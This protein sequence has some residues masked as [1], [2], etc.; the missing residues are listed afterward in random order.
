MNYKKHYHVKHLEDYK[1]FEFDK[2]EN[3]MIKIIKK[4]GHRNCIVFKI[5]NGNLFP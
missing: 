1:L 3:E 5:S 4:Y 2:N